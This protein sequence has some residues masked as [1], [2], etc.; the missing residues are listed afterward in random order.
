MLLRTGA[1]CR[2]ANNTRHPVQT[3]YGRQRPAPG[4]RRFGTRSSVPRRRTARPGSRSRMEVQTPAAGRPPARLWVGA[5]PPEDAGSQ[6]LERLLD[7]H[8]PAT[9]KTR[10][11]GQGRGRPPKNAVGV[12]ARPAGGR[13]R[14]TRSRWRTSWKTCGT[15]IPGVCVL[16]RIASARPPPSLE[17]EVIP[18]HAKGISHVRR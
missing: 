12:P 5:W 11:D 16:T 14:A 2:I 10:V 7:R 18:L 6:T 3:C 4:V 1:W 15:E 17:S 8:G 13:R 9:G